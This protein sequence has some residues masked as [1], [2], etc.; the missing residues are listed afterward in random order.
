MLMPSIASVPHCEHGISVFYDLERLGWWVIHGAGGE[1]RRFWPD[2]DLLELRDW[3]HVRGPL[4]VQKWLEEIHKYE[5]VN[6]A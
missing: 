2:I 3:S 4:L 1:A 5:G 6:D